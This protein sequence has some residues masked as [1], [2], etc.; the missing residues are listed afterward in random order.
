[1][2]IAGENLGEATHGA[3]CSLDN[4]ALQQDFRVF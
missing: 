4:A 3:H 2:S 1:V